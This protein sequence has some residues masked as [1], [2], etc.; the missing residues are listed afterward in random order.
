MTSTY[1]RH[2]PQIPFAVV[3][4]AR[5]SPVATPATA[6]AHTHAPRWLLVKTALRTSRTRRPQ[7]DAIHV[8]SH[9][10]TGHETCSSARR[11]LRLRQRAHQSAARRQ[12]P[13]DVRASECLDRG[14]PKR[15][16]FGARRLRRGAAAGGLLA[17]GAPEARTRGAVLR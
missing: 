1:P 6:L 7:V 5:K 2:L 16:W 8:S 3:N 13:S 17:P 15:V 11:H 12:G 14:L 9:H 10:E 4:V